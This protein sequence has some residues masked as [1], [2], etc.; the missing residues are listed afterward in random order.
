ME[1]NQQTDNQPESDPED[2]FGDTTLGPACSMDNP[3]CESCQ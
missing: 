1:T 2:D 3:D